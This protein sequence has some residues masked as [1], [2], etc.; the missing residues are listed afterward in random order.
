MNATHTI[1]NFNKSRDRMKRLCAL[2]RIDD[3]KNANFDEGVLI[4]S[5]LF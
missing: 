5:A 2:S 1:N 3:T 4:L